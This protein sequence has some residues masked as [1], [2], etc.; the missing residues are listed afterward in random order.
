MATR[1][2]TAENKS[3]K[4]TMSQGTATPE[5]NMEHDPRL[6][7]LLEKMM[8]SQNE[9]KDQLGML[10]QEMTDI[11]KE[12]TQ[13][14][15]I[16]DT[17][18]QIKRA[19]K[20]N[21]E[22]T[23]EVEDKLET[24]KERFE[25]QLDNSAMLEYR[26]KETYL[27]IRGFPE[28]DRENLEERM[29]PI[30]SMIWKIDERDVNREVDR[31]YRVNSKIAKDRK[32]PR[33]IVIN[34]TRK[35]LRDQILHYHSA[36]KLQVDGKDL[37]ILKEIPVSIRRKRKDYEGLVDIL[38]LNEINFRWNIPEG[39]FF[40]YNGKNYNITTVSKA[41]EFMARNKKNLKGLCQ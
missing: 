1:K 6:E 4:V 19:L 32:L 15:K 34:F 2:A 16:D 39:L 21:T 9:I 7:Q 28:V 5:K 26:Q 14:K 40:Q 18:N 27:R 35:L 3:L 25:I 22:H 37:I 11:K 23:N 20:D 29:N 12:M 33:D 17:L 30:L 31:M 41:Q 36:N 10:R 13:F 8:N 24:L 38:R